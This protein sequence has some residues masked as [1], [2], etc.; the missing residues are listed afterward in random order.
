MTAYPLTALATILALFVYG[1]MGTVVSRARAAYGVPAP[2]ISGHPDFE[3]RFRVQMNTLEQMPF[4]LPLMWLCAVWVGDPWAGLGGLV[5][6]IGRV[7][8]AI[9]YY[10][11]AHR[12]ELGFLIGSV[13]LAAMTAAVVVAIVIAWT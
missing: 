13:P 12:R 3:R 2:A 10:R 6:S 9:G 4:L 11:E 1:G 8:Y 5:W 7:I